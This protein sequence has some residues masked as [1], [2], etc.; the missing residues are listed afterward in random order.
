MTKSNSNPLKI[1]LF[2]GSFQPFHYGHKNI[3][4]DF[5]KENDLNLLIIVPNYVSPFKVNETDN[6][7]SYNNERLAQIKSNISTLESILR[8]KIIISNYEIDKA[9]ISYT[10]DTLT[11]YQ[12]E[13]QRLISVY[14]NT[15]N[16]NRNFTLHFLIGDDNLTNFDKW[17]NWE[18]ILEISDLVV[19]RRNYEENQ[20]LEIINSKYIEYTKKIHILK[21][22]YYYISSTKI[23]N[24]K[25]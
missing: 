6:S 5:I 11:Y 15:E 20:I 9:G 13:I 25:I 10:I 21:N 22:P 14:E 3:I 2:G 16:E 1:G 19:A 7:V 23:R 4:V 12:N 17:R 24:K 18:K 8:E